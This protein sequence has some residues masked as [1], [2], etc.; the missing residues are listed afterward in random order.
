MFPR[1]VA[2]LVVCDYRGQAGR[3]RWDGT[4][5][6]IPSGLA[7]PFA[8]TVNGGASTRSNF[9]CKV[10]SVGR[11]YLLA[12]DGSDNPMPLVYVTG[13][14]CSL[15]FTNGTATRY[16]GPD[17]RA[18]AAVQQVFRALRVALGSF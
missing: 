2:R 13:D 5:V 9:L 6:R 15:V 12:A 18:A 8:R 16:L 11:D 4:T 7:Q 3:D 14:G 17:G 10:R 1:P